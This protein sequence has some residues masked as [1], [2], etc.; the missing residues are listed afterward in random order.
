MI[1]NN[2][3]FYGIF[4]DY[5]DYQTLDIFKKIRDNGVIYYVLYNRFSIR[6][7]KLMR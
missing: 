6:T 3:P 7:K 2:L 1:F 4:F 5:I